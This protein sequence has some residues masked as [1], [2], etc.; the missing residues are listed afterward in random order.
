MERLGTERRSG[1]VLIT[2]LEDEGLG[3]FSGRFV[4]HWEP[5]DSGV[6]I[7]GP[8]GVSIED[9][10]EWGRQ[11]ADKIS[12]LIGDDDIPYSAGAHVL[13]G[14][15]MWPSGGISVSTRPWGAPVDGRQQAVGWSFRAT[16]EN[17][18]HDPALGDEI[19][20]AFNQESRVLSAEEGLG[21]PNV[22]LKFQVLASDLEGAVRVA[23][24][25]TER[26]LAKHGVACSEWS[27]SIG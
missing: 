13:E 23:H 25:I 24:T 15:K 26:V 9:A 19:V 21:L 3:R 27:V 18:R 17:R 7:D 10:I 4:A 2:E 5:A 16:V 11:Q 12:V 6:A 8:E 22:T 14:H 20:A 1:T